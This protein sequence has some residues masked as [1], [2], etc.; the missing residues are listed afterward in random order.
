MVP[1]LGQAVLAATE[2]HTLFNLNPH[3][4][5]HIDPH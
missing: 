1:S 5:F 3:P 4:E 2:I